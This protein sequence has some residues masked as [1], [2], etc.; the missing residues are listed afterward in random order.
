MVAIAA[1][2]AA[3]V[4]LARG[5]AVG[6]GVVDVKITLFAVARLEH[7]VAAYPEL[8]WFEIDAGR[9]QGGGDCDGGR[10]A[11]SSL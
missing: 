8:E 10:K 6:V 9:C 11:T 5:Y 2:V 4:A 1:A 3:A 7:T